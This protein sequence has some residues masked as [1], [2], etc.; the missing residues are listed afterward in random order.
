MNTDVGAVI[1]EL[2][3][4]IASQQARIDD[5]SRWC[6]FVYADGTYAY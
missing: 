2:R 6:D 5:L 1:D 3:A 4:T